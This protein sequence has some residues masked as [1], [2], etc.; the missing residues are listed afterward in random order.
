[1]ASVLA[2]MMNR[3]QQYSRGFVS[4]RPDHMGGKE[5]TNSETPVMQSSLFI[6]GRVDSR[7]RMRV[8]H[9]A[10]VGDRVLVGVLS[11]RA[12]S[13]GILYRSAYS[14]NL[15]SPVHLRDLGACRTDLQLPVAGRAAA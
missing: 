15:Q 5:H 12:N 13:A 2:S 1:M 7:G 6:E 8:G 9:L 14:S 3:V 4:I 11:R 10:M